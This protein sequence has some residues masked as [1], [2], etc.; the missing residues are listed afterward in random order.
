MLIAGGSS[1][2]GWKDNLSSAEIYDPGTGKFAAAASLNDSRFKLPDET[3][4][5]A[6]GEL[7]I[8]GGSKEV[9]L[10]DR[11]SGKFR[12]ALGELT[13]RW[14]FMSE[15][16]RRDGRVLLA[17]DYANDDKATAQAWIYQQ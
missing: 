4:Q 16:K 15:T 13:D 8:A 14:H 2:R 1:S 5:L 7:L 11:A 12:A 17:G 6:S 3:A 9:E 10:F